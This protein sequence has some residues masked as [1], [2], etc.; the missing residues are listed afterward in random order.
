[1]S[2]MYVAAVIVSQ[3]ALAWP[4]ALDSVGAPP[5]RRI[6]AADYGRYGAYVLL[7]YRENIVE[8][9][10]VV[11]FRFN[12]EGEEQTLWTKDLAFVPHRLLVSDW[13]AVVAANEYGRAGYKHTLVV[14]SN[15]GNVLVDYGLEDIL[16]AE[17]IT[18]HVVKTVSSR[19]W[20]LGARYTFTRRE[21]LVELS[22]GKKLVVDL[23]SGAIVGQLEVDDESDR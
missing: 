2:R 23:T 1:M 7:K 21:L 20:D 14:F 8:D 17:E 16:T 12:K 15:A 10:K 19:R 22:W 11:S 9:V 18:S 4:L 5:V 3:I 6:F 13:G